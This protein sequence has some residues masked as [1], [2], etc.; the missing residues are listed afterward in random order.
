MKNIGTAIFYQ[1]GKTTTKADELTEQGWTKCHS[2][3]HN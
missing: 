2:C 3:W 1:K